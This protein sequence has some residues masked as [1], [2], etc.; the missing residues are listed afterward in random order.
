MKK[1]FVLALVLLML[2]AFTGCGSFV[3]E[4]CEKEKSGEK[5][6]I[7]IFGVKAVVCDECYEEIG[8]GIENL[9]KAVDELEDIDFNEVG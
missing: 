1:I 2:F 8:E 6:E 3:C 9:E 5:H 7:D 4:N